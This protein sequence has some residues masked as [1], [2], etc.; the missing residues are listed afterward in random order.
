MAD[1][2]YV[3]GHLNPL[4]EGVL[5]GLSAMVV[6]ECGHLIAALLLHV[7]IKSVRVKW[8]GICTVRDTGTPLQ[9]LLISI[10]GPVLNSLLAFTWMWSEA[11][12]LA[13]VCV[14]LVNVL[15]LE[16]SDG[17]RALTCWKELKAR[18]RS[19]IKSI[20]ACLPDAA[21]QAQQVPIRAFGQ[22]RGC[23]S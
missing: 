8:R 1:L 13:N 19:S 7:K 22:V 5:I 20:D 16:R 21:R 17:D 23:G 18:A 10:A 12:S 11:F 3:M 14:A 15:P 2:M 9:N 4:I 6:H